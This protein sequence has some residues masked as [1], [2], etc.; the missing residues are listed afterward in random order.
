MPAPLRRELIGHDV[1]T[2]YELGWAAFANGELLEIAEADFEVFITTDRDP[3]MP[4]RHGEHGSAA[5]LLG[6]LASRA[7]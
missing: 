6:D 4:G 5:G 7:G 3:L 2:A 1:A